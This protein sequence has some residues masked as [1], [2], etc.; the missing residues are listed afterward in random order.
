MP[1]LAANLTML[2]T[3][4]PF[5]DRFERAARAGFGA[6]EFLFPYDH[7]AREIATALEENRL[8]RA[9]F[10]M[11]PGDWAAGERGLA[12]DPRQ[13]ARFR[14]ALALALD[15]AAVLGAPL[16]HCMAGVAPKEID[17]RE[18]EENFTDNLA[19]AAAEAARRGVRIVIEPLNRFDMPGYFLETM[20]EAAAILDRVG[21]DNLSLQYDIY[22][23][24]R[25]GGEIVATFERHR[26]RIA[27]IQIAGNPGRHEPD[28][29]EIDYRAVLAALDARGYSG[30]V[31][32]EYL[33][34]GRTEDGLGWAR[35]YLEKQG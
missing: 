32:C 16:I 19:H 33:P 1:R 27:H 9:L 28:C 18:L 29:G 22:H 5:M 26:A 30:F 20:A 12:V 8:D 14:E 34:A 13:R 35:D 2:F 25:T 6:V 31:G 4:V 23:Q 10:N 15:Y 3:E 11:P 24:S 17:R 7:D 21:S